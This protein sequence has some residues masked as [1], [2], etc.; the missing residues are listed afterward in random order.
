MFDDYYSRPAVPEA[1]KIGNKLY[2]DCL[3]F[4]TINSHYLKWSDEEKAME[5]IISKTCGLVSYRYPDGRIYTRLPESHD[6]PQFL[7]KPY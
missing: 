2:M 4:D 7:I 6:K 5:F 1:V 3:V